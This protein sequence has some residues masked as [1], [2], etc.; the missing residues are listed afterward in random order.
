MIVLTLYVIKTK[1]ACKSKHVQ[2]DNSNKEQQKEIH[3]SN[4]N[5]VKD[6]DDD[7]GQHYC[8]LLYRQFG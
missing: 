5:I 1:W 4:N 6:D 2:V 3:N 7:D 8:H